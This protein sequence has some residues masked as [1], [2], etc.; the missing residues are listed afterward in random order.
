MSAA[1]WAFMAKKFLLVQR[2]YASQRRP[3]MG[4]SVRLAPDCGGA[5]PKSRFIW[6]DC[7]RHSALRVAVPA[8]STTRGSSEPL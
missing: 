5:Q 4:D 1:C 3:S 8:G 2:E 6:A 7:R